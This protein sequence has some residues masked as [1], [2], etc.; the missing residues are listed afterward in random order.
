MPITAVVLTYNEELH[1][2]RCLERLRG[3]ADRLVIIDSF[4]TDSTV[5]IAQAAGA[6]VFQHAFTN[7]AAQFAWGLEAAAIDT[8]WVLRMDADEYLEEALIADIRKT[9][10]E[11]P[12]DITG[13]EMRRKV[14]FQGQWIR[15]GGYYKTVLTRMWRAGAAHVEQRWMDE[16]VAMLRGRTIW[17]KA[18]DLVDDNLKDL[19]WWT[20]KHNGYTTR[21]MVE[22]LNLEY[23]LFP[24]ADVG[25]ELSV[26][27]QRKRFLR[28]SIYARSPLYLRATLYF[29]QRYF[30]R[31]GLLDGR[32]GFVFHF[33]Q[34]YWNFM[35]MDAKVDE[36][37]RFIAAHGVEAF[38]RH[39][40]ERHNIRLVT[41]PNG[42]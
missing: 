42:S 39:L 15:W 27:A 21:Q 38:R 40:A 5:D 25:D 26:R 18:G 19:S 28:N 24:R 13:I 37:R 12:D 11:L 41:G 23:D 10:P 14:F 33:L 36:G 35:L 1:I 3:V 20:D 9:L 29:L 17:L 4:S 8:G 30:L 31:L 16:H 32:K 22:F 2:G 6:E 7:H 34:G